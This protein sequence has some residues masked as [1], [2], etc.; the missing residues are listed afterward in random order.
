MEEYK[1]NCPE[2]GEELTYSRLGNLN[3]A[4]KRNKP[5]ASCSKKGKK[6]KKNHPEVVQNIC[7][8]CQEPYE[9]IWKN[10]HHRFCCKPC[11]YEWRKNKTNKEW[12]K[13]T[14]V[15]K[16]L[17]CGE[18]FRRYKEGNKYRNGQL[19][20][21]CSNECNRSSDYKKEKLRKWG[22]SDANPRKDPKVKA[23]IKETNLKRYGNPNYNNTEKNMKTTMERYGVPFGFMKNPSNGKRIS[24]GQR[25]L[26]DQIK[27]KHKDALLEHWLPDVQKSVDIFIPSQNKIVEYYGRYWH[28]DPNKYEPDYYHKVM[29]MT[30]EEIWKRD[31]DRER[32]LMGAGYK[33]EI[34][35][36]NK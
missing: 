2:C 27:K 19:R 35:W 31:G 34:V 15:V 9:I 23:K 14:E 30:A 8:W 36:E 28:A 24:E 13:K 21:F 6:T 5:C 25:Q 18:L 3:L 17:H 33:V 20:L 12:L 4:K 11:M 7:E 22:L 32:E 1:R 29:K 26:F 16:C 10:R